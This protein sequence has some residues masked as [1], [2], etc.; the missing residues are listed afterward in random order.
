MPFLAYAH[1]T[2]SR[3]SVETV[4]ALPPVHAIS[5]PTDTNWYHIFDA[6]AVRLTF[7]LSTK[8]TSVMMPVYSVMKTSCHFDRLHYK[9]AA[10]RI[11]T[12]HCHRLSP[13]RRLRLYPSSSRPALPSESQRSREE[14]PPRS[15]YSSTLHAG[16]VFKMV[17][18]WEP[19]LGALH[20]IYI[21]FVKVNAFVQLLKTIDKSTSV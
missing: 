20:R 3:V 4:Y 18:V 11:A 17:I 6:I 12:L 16:R 1:K 10:S 5:K 13:I 2:W 14:S 15:L 19:D 21:Y 9:G 7:P 8:D